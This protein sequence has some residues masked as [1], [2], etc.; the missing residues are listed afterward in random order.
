VRGA[1]VREAAR[2][3][4]RVAA[5]AAVV[6]AVVGRVAVWVELPAVAAAPG[7]HLRA[8]AEVVM[9]VVGPAA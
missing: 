1:G 8:G 5:T 7:E 3:V 6:T 4:A 2:A 9:A